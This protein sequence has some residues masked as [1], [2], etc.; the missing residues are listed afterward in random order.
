MGQE[1]FNFV[2]LYSLAQIEKDKSVLQNCFTSE[3]PVNM[4]NIG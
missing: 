1:I 4:M 2:G 3:V